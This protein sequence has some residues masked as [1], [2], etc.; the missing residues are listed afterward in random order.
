M[1]IFDVKV[2]RSDRIQFNKIGSSW[3]VLMN[4]INALDETTLVKMLRWELD[5]RRRMFVLNRLKSRHNR[6]RDARERAE[7][8]RERV[9]A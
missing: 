2:T 1:N 8:F 3:N 5:D 6:L 4:H 9:D 7:L